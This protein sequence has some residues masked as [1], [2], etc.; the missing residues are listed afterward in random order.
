MVQAAAVLAG[1]GLLVLLHELGH[2]AAA[3]A[4]RLRVTDVSL[5][6]G[7]SLARRAVG[8][9]TLRLGLVPF[10]GYVR[11][12][13]LLPGEGGDG[14][15]RFAPAAVA[16]RAAAILGGS[17]ANLLLAGA[18]AGVSAAAFGVDS[19]RV[20][21]LEVTAAPPGPI[22]V[23]DV[24]T[25]VEGEPV[26]RVGDL[27]RLLGSGQGEP[28]TVRLQREGRT[29]EASVTPRRAGRRY[30][31]GAR[32]AVLPELRRVGAVEAALHGAIYPFAEAR[33][34]LAR[35]AQS[36]APGSGVR[37]VT[38]VGLADRVS[39]SGRWD[40]RRGLGLA[41]ILAVAV[42]LWN[43]LPLPGLDGGRLVLEAVE[44]ARRRRL[45]PRVALLVQLG[46]ALA[47]LV[48]WAVLLAVDLSRLG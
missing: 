15:T 29:L 3:R 4:V 9:V 41:A 32:Y 46:G 1:L 37:Q 36:L 24:V 13:E 34:L 16:R 35:A 44:T 33:R 42:G 11:V 8:G 20:S 30:G 31:L 25:H 48:A 7:P 17:A 19:G 40:L 26:T 12:P 47:L 22:V 14:P 5:G 23:G 28:V 39:R 10:G 6:L 43:L 27:G 21:G 45:L 18:L 2:A 38:A